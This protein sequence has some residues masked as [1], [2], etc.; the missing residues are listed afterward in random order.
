MRAEF[1]N[2]QGP[3]VTRAE[4]RDDGCKRL[5]NGLNAVADHCAHCDALLRAARPRPYRVY[6]D[7]G[8]VIHDWH[9]H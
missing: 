4:R 8:R 5:R 9:I 6:E 1:V 7:D 2:A 3:S